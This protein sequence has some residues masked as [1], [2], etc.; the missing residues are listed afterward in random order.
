M[1]LVSEHDHTFETRTLAPGVTLHLN[2]SSKRK[3]HQLNVYWIGDLDEDVTSRAL[4]PSVL[5]R[6]TETHP[7]MRDVTRRLEYLYGAGFSGDVMKIGERHAIVFRADLANERFLPAGESLLGPMMEFVAEVLQRPRLVDGEFPADVLDN[8]KENHRRLIEGLL[9][10]KGAYAREHCLQEMCRD[11]RFQLYEYGR[12]VDLPSISTESLTELWRRQLAG[13]QTH[14]YFSGDLTRDAMADALAP[15]GGERDG[16]PLPVRDLPEL[17]GASE[18]REVEERLAVEQAKLLLGYRTRTRFGDPLLEA[19]TI[20]CGILG[21]FAHSKLFLNVREK[22]SLCYSV[23]STLDRTH[24]LMLISAGI[25]IDKREQA[26]QLINEQLAAMQN[27][28]FTDEELAAT[29]NAYENR[30]LMAEDNPAA[31]MDI[32]LTW[33]LAGITYDHSRY[34]E[35]LSA[36]TREQVVEAIRCV[37]P[38]IVYLLRPE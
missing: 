31:L 2:S 5:Q 22:A 11:E 3:T 26:Q 32:D 6:G 23:S 20:A 9:N 25:D 24:G 19:L 18:L 37:E 8:E 38:E 7:S 30:L 15:L 27:G 28:D 36:V 12:V 1:N 21:Q 16:D 17:R 34:R 14:I 10:S 4:L 13:A 33:R 35:R 29:K